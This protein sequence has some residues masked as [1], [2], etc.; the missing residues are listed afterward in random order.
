M[1]TDGIGVQGVQGM[2][3]VHGMDVQGV[4]P[5]NDLKSSVICEVTSVNSHHE[6]W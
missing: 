3:G 4:A 5:S 6:G 2:Q 1:S